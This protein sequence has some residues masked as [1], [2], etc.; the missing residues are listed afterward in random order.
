[1]GFRHKTTGSYGETRERSRGTQGWA[2]P[3]STQDSTGREGAERGC[4][5]P[6]AQPLLPRPVRAHSVPEESCPESG[7]RTLGRDG[8]GCQDR[9]TGWK[10][11]APETEAG[12][13]SL[14]SPRPTDGGCPPPAPHSPALGLQQALQ[15]HKAHQQPL[16]VFASE[17]R[18]PGDG[19]WPAS[20]GPTAPTAEEG[21]LP[22]SLTASCWGTASGSRPSSAGGTFW[23]LCHTAA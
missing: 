2:D 14:L 17:I 21:L 15:V 18:S 22:P 7:H 1:M 20:R 11:C 10:R 23:Q 19:E 4:G 13:P 9:L 5:A 8:E 12:T 16:N 6:P 3:Q